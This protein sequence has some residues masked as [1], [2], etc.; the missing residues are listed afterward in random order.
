[1]RIENINVLKR[2]SNFDVLRWLCSL[3]VIFQ[4]FCEPSLWNAFGISLEKSY[5][6]YIFLLFFYGI[7][8]V[9]VPVFLILSGYFSINKKEQKLGKALYLFAEVIIFS[10]IS[11]FAYFLF[12]VLNNNISFSVS[13]FFLSFFPHNYYLYLFVGVYFLSPFLNK[14]FLSLSKKQFLYFLIIS[15]SLF[16][17]WSTIVNAFSLDFD[18]FYFVGKSGTDMGFTLINFL[19]LYS[20]GCYIKLYYVPKRK[21]DLLISSIAIFATTSVLLLGKIGVPLIKNLY[22]YDSMFVIASSVCFVIFFANINVKYNK[23]F[24]FL[25]ARTFGI[26]LISNLS[27]YI[28]NH[29]VSINSLISVGFHGVIFSMLLF[30]LGS[31][32][33]SLFIV[34][35]VY[36]CLLPI[37]KKIKKTKVY[38]LDICPEY[39]IE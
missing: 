34:S 29:F 4:H 7:S 11:F 28:I 35:S 20:L 23:I 1:M 16:S 12:G 13:S 36:F 22:Y 24:S 14:L 10:L 21:R 6:G 27:I 37:T 38:N 39:K 8:R 18:G 26:Y 17:V 19:F 9:A 33:L 3:F 32:C 30:V 15:F 31:Y 25:G 5:M 2:Q